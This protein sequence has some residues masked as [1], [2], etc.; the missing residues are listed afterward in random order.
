MHFGS[1]YNGAYNSTSRMVITGAGNVGIGTASPTTALTIRKAIASAAYGQQASMIEFKSYFPGY[2]TETV[3]SAIYSGVSG[4]GTLNTQGGYMSFH[5]NNN[6][7]MGEKM[8]IEKSGIVTKPYQPSFNAYRTNSSMNIAVDDKFIFNATTHDVGGMY[9]TS[10]GRITA[11]VAGKYLFQFHTIFQGNYGNTYIQFFVNNA[12]S[13]ELGDYHLS[14][15]VSATSHWQTHNFS[16]V[17]HL[18]AN[19]YIDIYARSAFT[20][21]GTHWGGLSCHLLS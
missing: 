9:N 10:T 18:S 1:L 13:Y 16:R 5:V 17:I 20:W 4:E 8:R 14:Q 6:G 3:K 21:H 11:P 15:V 19:D 12:R 2:D 7:T